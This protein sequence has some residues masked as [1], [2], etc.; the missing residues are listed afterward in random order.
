MR[1]QRLGRVR[2]GTLEDDAIGGERIDGWRSHLAVTVC[3][4]VIRP[5]RVDG[6]DHNRTAH[7]RRCAGVTPAADGGQNGAD[8]DEHQNE[9]VAEWARQLPVHLIKSG[10]GQRRFGGDRIDREHLGQIFRGA[11]LV[12]SLQRQHA[13]PMQRAAP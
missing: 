2:E 13:Q 6:D 7:R 9:R 1:R 10:F 3:G 12:S 4:Q 5:E 8:C 11:G